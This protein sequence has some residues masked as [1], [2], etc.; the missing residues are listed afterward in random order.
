MLLIAV[1]QTTHSEVYES[2]ELTN[3][4][5]LYQPILSN[6]DDGHIN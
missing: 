2:N 5:S 6:D 1:A 3:L 4:S